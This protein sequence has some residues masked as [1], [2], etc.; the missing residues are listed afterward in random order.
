MNELQADKGRVTGAEKAAR[1]G[2]QR[3]GVLRGEAVLTLQ[4]RQAQRLVKGRA[5]T[6]DRARIVGLLTFATLVRIVWR[7]AGQGDPYAEWWLVKV[8]AALACGERAVMESQ[9]ALDRRLAS[10]EALQ[11]SRPASVKPARVALQFG[12]PYAF[13]AARLVGRFDGVAR[14]ALC[15]RHVGALSDAAAEAEL[16]RAARQVRRALQGANGYRPL[17]TTRDDL[18]LSTARGRKARSAMGKLPEDILGRA[19]RAP[20]LPAQATDSEAS[21]PAGFGEALGDGE[22]VAVAG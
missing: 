5:G 6:A 7:R 12:N 10:V 22:A 21:V 14:T 4:T 13:R 16:N 18:A 19:R 11:V 2:A 3:A 1:Q 20:S 9:A 8:D 15:A 17:G